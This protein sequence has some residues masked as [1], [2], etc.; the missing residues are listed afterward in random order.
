MTSVLSSAPD[1]ARQ[2]RPDINGLR[3]IAILSVLFFHLGIPG[4]SGGFVGVDI[5]FVISGFLITGIIYDEYILTG[6]FN[7]S[8]FY[9]RR[10]RRLFPALVFTLALTFIAGFFL[11]ALKFFDSFSL[12]L[13]SA[14]FSV[15]N[16][17]FW[18]TRDYFAPNAEFEPLLHTWSLSVE[19]QFYLL[20]PIT[21]IF[22]LKRF[23]KPGAVIFLVVISLISL[24]LNAFFKNNSELIFYMLPF[25]VFEFA[26]GALLVWLIKYQPFDKKRLE[27]LAVTTTGIL[28]RLIGVRCW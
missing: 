22:I 12:S 6:R 10:V 8:N 27:V 18:K 9:I 7:F 26:I 16:F 20:W 2:Y 21:L 11:L 28:I 14:L 4:V 23:Q 13:I 25:R 1:T 24:G 17:Y 19:E 5:F 15:S 3:A